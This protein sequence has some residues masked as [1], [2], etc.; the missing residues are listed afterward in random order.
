[1]IGTALRD[2][3]NVGL[4]DLTPVTLVAA[5]RKLL[6]IACAIYRS[7]SSPGA[8]CSRRK[9]GK[10]PESNVGSQDLTPILP[11]YWWQRLV[12]LRTALNCAGLRKRATSIFLGP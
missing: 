4:Q 9:K 12:H 11:L 5:A 2:G 8:I 7:T 10:S 6:H 1:V 3:A